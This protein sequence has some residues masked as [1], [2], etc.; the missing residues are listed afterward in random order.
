MDC[1]TC[2][3]SLWEYNDPDLDRDVVRQMTEHL[4]A[5]PTC[6]REL[7][8][9]TDTSIFLK[10]YMPV[11]TVDC[12]FVQATMDK[13]LLSESAASFLK[14]IF[15]VGLALSFLN[16]VVMII[17]CPTCINLLFSIGAMLFAFVKLGALVIQAAP[18]L[19]IV[20]GIAISALLFVVLAFARQLSMRRI[21]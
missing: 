17:I 3:G 14:P 9:L 12:A 2:M 10:E 8:A 7:R 5:C 20:F 11:L 4:A 16:L 6:S 19:Q 18:V 21:A 13:I 1:K 15:G